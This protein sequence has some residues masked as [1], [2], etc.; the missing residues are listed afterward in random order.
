MLVWLLENTMNKNQKIKMEPKS[1]G[2]IEPLVEKLAVHFGFNPV[3]PKLFGEALTH[4]SYS[5]EHKIPSN[6]RLEFLGDSVLSLIV[7][8]FLYKTYPKYDEGDLA[9][10]KSIIVS[11][12]VWASLAK[13]MKLDSYIKLGAGESRNNG[14]TKPNILADL[15]EA[16]I[17]AYFLNFGLERTTEFVEPLIKDN[18]K[19]LIHRFTLLNA[20]SDLQEMSQHQG[21][22]PTYR[23]IKEEGPP[24]Q[25]RFTVEVSLEDRP[26]GKG[27]G[28]SLKEAQNK[29]AL[30]AIAKLSRKDG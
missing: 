30:E 18:L 2:L 6:E 19:E 25:R 20:K 27:E 26:V 24:H 11:T 12:Q 16:F 28:R 29:A 3:Y 4:S 14:Q 5:N 8:T 1:D 22:F 9:K 23:T 15:F 17:G 21:L 7:V 10:L 13:Q